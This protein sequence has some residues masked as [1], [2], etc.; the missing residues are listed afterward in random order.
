M[1]VPVFATGTSTYLGKGVC[2]YFNCFLCYM[3]H[4]FQNKDRSLPGEHLSN[5]RI[6]ILYGLPRIHIMF[7]YFLVL[8]LIFSSFSSLTLSNLKIQEQTCKSY[9]SA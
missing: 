1:L 9:S 7:A 2:H 6:S 4:C 5:P 3:I 8:D